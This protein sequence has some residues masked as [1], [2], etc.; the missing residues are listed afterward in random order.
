MFD[1]KLQDQAIEN[2]IGEAVIFQKIPGGELMGRSQK[3]DRWNVLRG[4]PWIKYPRSL[5]M[6]TDFCVHF[7]D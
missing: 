6:D 5:L 2:S 1:E 7:S 3:K 4:R